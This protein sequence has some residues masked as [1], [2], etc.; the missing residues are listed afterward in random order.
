MKKI[1][2]LFILLFLGV[3]I[4]RSETY[5]SKENPDY[6]VEYITPGAQAFSVEECQE[7]SRQH[8]GNIVKC[9]S[10]FTNHFYSRGEIVDSKIDD[11]AKNAYLNRVQEK[12]QTEVSEQTNTV[13]GLLLFAVITVF[14]TFG[15]I[16]IVKG[17][18]Q[19]AIFF[20]SWRDFFATF[21]YTIAICGGIVGTI[22]GISGL[23]MKDG[24]PWWI[25][26]VSFGAFIVGCYLNARVPYKYSDNKFTAFCVF[27]GRIWA[28]F[29][30]LFIL[31]GW[32]GPGGKRKDESDAGY[33]IRTAMHYAMWTAI[34]VW[35]T[36]LASN[37]VNGE[38]LL[39]D[40]NFGEAVR[41]R[42]RFT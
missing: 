3:G 29:L 19:E 13:L 39:E 9:Q 1:L 10:L 2:S 33:A 21:L 30:T 18:K 36:R 23:V 12:K 31:V 16:G 14:L 34:T 6:T 17:Y 41:V 24:N 27:V 20:Y 32:L 26:P 38:R 8:P 22:S 42:S 28:M 37:L 4:A 5:V 35:F 25:G 7:W 15:I 11:I 40:K